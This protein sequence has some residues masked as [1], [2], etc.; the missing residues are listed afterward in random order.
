MGNLSWMLIRWLSEASQ[1]APTSPAIS[2]STVHFDKTACYG[3]ETIGMDCGFL[4]N[5]PS[6]GNLP[7]AFPAAVKKD[8]GHE[9]VLVFLLLP[10]CQ[11]W[12]TVEKSDIG[13]T[14]GSGRNNLGVFADAGLALQTSNQISTPI[15]SGILHEEG[16]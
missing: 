5:L 7:A 12:D 9:S 1:S 15:R 2:W 13:C 3:G 10:P 6:G 4:N 8:T 11:I 16:L 14:A